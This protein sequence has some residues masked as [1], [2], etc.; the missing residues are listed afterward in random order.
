MTNKTPWLNTQLPWMQRYLLVVCVL[1]GMLFSPLTLAGALVT[2]GMSSNPYDT[3]QPAVSASTQPRFSLVLFYMASCP[4]CQRFEPTLLRFMQAHHLPLLA[5]TLDGGVSPNLAQSQVPTLKEIK[6]FFPNKQPVT[7]TLFLID[8][9]THRIV[10]FIQ[11]EAS[12]EQME[13]TA[14]TIIRNILSEQGAPA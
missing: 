4:H 3:A 6:H 1:L 12:D 10:P 5:F 2:D 8:N 7:P 13:A 11:G 9:Q 14:N